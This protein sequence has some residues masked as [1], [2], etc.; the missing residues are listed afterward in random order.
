MSGHSKWSTIKR[1][2]GKL[3][4]QRG[5]IFTRCIKEIIIAAREGGGDPSGNARL[6]AAVTAAKAANMPAANIE[7]AIKKGTGELPGAS[8]EEYTYE[9]YGHGGVAIFLEVL[10]DNRNRTT[11]EIRHLFGK[12]GGN[13]GQDGCVAW[14]FEPKGIITIA[15]GAIGE[16]RLLEVALD[17]GADDVSGDSDDAFEVYATI[18]DLARVAQ[19]LTDAGIP[20]MSAEPSRVPQNT[21]LLGEEE[22]VKL[23]KLLEALEEHDDIQ[24]VYANFDVST[25]TMN[26]LKAE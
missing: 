21:V 16:E 22:A 17:A 25:D 19:A 10:S 9:G 6:R 20:L 1:K 11:A 2:K 15:R 13:L 24:K 23:M 4:A 7:R 14:M 5:K 12:Y 8:Y 26:K 3:D 18:P